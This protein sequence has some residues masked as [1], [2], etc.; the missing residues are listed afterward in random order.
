MT[1]KQLLHIRE[2]INSM[3]KKDPEITDVVIS[4]QVRES[5]IR[6]IANIT[7]KL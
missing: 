5:R 6:N 1:A 7:I 3:I 4:Y 2:E